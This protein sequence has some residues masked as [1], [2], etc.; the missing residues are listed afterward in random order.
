MLIRAGL[1]RQITRPA[2]PAAANRAA[3]RPGVSGRHAAENRL[4]GLGARLNG[5]AGPVVQRLVAY[6]HDNKLYINDE[7]NDPPP[8][9][10]AKVPPAQYGEGWSLSPPASNEYIDYV[11]DELV[12]A[13]LAGDA[14]R[15][16][17][18]ERALARTTSR[19]QIEFVLGVVEDQ[20][21][22][23]VLTSDNPDPA[24]FALALHQVAGI[25][26]A[27]ELLQQYET[28]EGS[29]QE[30]FLRQIVLTREMYRAGKLISV[31]QNQN[32]PSG[33]PAYVKADIVTRG[34]TGGEV[35]M[36]V[37]NWP[38]FES[39]HANVKAQRTAELLAQLDRYGQ[40]GKP[41]ELHWT[42]GAMPEDLRQKIVAVSHK[43]G[44]RIRIVI[45]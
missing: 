30:G 13:V 38:G 11:T 28:S 31:E 6:H 32:K 16:A 27:D 5:G 45:D 41:V 21:L 42:G 39:L 1:S 17:E 2:G 15:K 37:K 29:E 3:V 14:D 33:E 36:E 24:D 19:A 35:L 12:K 44:D 23:D 26:G 4:A 40:T 25:P 8:Q 18:L 10:Y 34:D 7:T 22:A 43:Y 9:G 20:R